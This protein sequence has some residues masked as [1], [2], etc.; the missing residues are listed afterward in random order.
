MVTYLVRHMRRFGEN[1]EIARV[2]DALSPPVEGRSYVGVR[3]RADSARSMD[4]R[5]SLN[6]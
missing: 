1:G 3:V 6:G 2:G 4:R 5:A